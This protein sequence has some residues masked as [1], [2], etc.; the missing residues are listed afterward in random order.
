MLISNAALSI[1]V[2][3]RI[4]LASVRAFYQMI[5]VVVMTISLSVAHTSSMSPSEQYILTITVWSMA[6]PILWA[7]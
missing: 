7:A 5:F 4:S 3:V 6:R 2:G 1:V